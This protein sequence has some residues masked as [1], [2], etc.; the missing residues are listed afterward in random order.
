M[1]SVYALAP[2]KIKF[3]R[4]K[5]HFRSVVSADAAISGLRLLLKVTSPANKVT[6]GL[7]MLLW[8]VTSPGF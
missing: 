6:T 2:L 5:S 3:L 1:I 8:N 4:V 7:V